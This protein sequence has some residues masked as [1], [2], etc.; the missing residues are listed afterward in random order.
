MASASSIPNPICPHYAA[1]PCS[2]LAI[3]RLPFG[4]GESLTYYFLTPPYVERLPY[5]TLFC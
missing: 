4:L 5:E 2:P 3:G 1:V